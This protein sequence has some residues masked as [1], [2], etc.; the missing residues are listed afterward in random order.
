ML[1]DSKN[2]VVNNFVLFLEENGMES[3][4]VKNGAE[5]GMDSISAIL[6]LI[7]NSWTNEKY[8]LKQNI[9]RDWIGFSLNKDVAFIGQ[10]KEMKEYIVFQPL[11]KLIKKAEKIYK[12]KSMNRGMDTDINDNY[13]FSKIKIKDISCYKTD[14]EQK[15]IFQKWINEEINIL[16]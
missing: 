12:E 4:I 5:N 16:L 1:A 14:K 3:S 11:G 7:E 13:I 6:S 10:L 15:Q 9:D 8:Q 2:E